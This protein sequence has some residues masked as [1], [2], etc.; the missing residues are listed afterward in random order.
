MASAHL[1]HIHRAESKLKRTEVPHVKP[2]GVMEE[3]ARL[4]PPRVA[5]LVDTKPGPWG[6]ANQF[7]KA[8]QKTLARRGLLGTN[9]FDCDV[10]L[11]N[12]HHCIRR[13]VMARRLRPHT[14]FVQ[15]I[16]GPMSLY[17]SGIDSRDRWVR[18]LNEQVADAIVFQ[19]EWS[20]RRNFELGIG[21]ERPETVI[22]NAADPDFF[23]SSPLSE[24]IE[25]CRSKLRL[26]A[27]C[28]SQNA[29][30]GF[31]F[32]RYL[33]A[34]LDFDRFAMTFVGRSPI[35]FKNIKMYD[36][37]PS[38]KLGSLLR[39]HDI[40]V[41]ASRRDPC[42]NSVLE[43]LACGLPVVARADGGHPEI[44]GSGGE[45]FVE[46]SEMLAKIDLVAG[47]LESYQARIPENDFDL[48]VTE[49]LEF[50]SKVLQ[51]RTEPIGA[52]RRRR[53]WKSLIEALY[54]SK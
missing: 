20:K 9:I 47:R 25:Q 41:S 36:A 5:I 12:S 3:S 19:S 45:L 52:V 32:Y 7:F 50:F 28:W 10:I 39:Q 1:T 18:F 30:K 16:D 34:N 53:L 14:C 31:E 54:G 40:F 22:S 27:T 8:F 35:K 42:S 46:F 17:T 24:K 48:V 43:A 33:D 11:F 6:G 26:I 4:R 2:V 21:R 15:R 23:F 51:G 13:V 49:Y 29:N 38:A 44:I 37:V